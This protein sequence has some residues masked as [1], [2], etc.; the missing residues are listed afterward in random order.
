MKVLIIDNYDSFTYNL[1]HYVEALGV[2]VDVLRNDAIDLDKIDEFEKIIISPG[3]GLPSTTLNMK[4]V[5]E[6][7]H[8]SKSI[9]GICLGMQ[10]IAEFFGGNLLN[11]LKVTHGVQTKINIVQPSVLFENMPENFLGGLYHSWKVDLDS[12]PSELTLTALS[13]SNVAMAIEHKKLPIFGV[14]FHPE[15]I[16]TEHGR[17]ILSNFINL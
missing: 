5:F 17:T 13:Q 4:N 15:S 9:L 16:L 10:G 11:Q 6:R 2:C 8:A 12:L 3:P 14:Q 1:K 7:Y